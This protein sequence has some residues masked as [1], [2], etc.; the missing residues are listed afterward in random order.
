MSRVGA[1]GEAELVAM[2]QRRL[3]SEMRHVRLGMG[4]DGAI[5]QVDGDLVAT[6]DSVVAGVDWLPEATPRQAIGHRAAAVNLSDLAA[7]GARPAH[8]LVALELP[9]SLAV[10]DLNESLDGLRRLAERHDAAV[11]GG[12]VGIGVGPERW[13]VTA[14]G[15]LG[16]GQALLRS[17]ALPGYG[18][19]LVGTCG[20]AQ[21]GLTALR[22]GGSA[23]GLAACIEAHLRPQPQCAA[24]L[25]LAACGHS[26]AAIDVSDGLWLDGSRLA[27]ASGVDLRLDVPIPPW[28]S[29]TVAGFC[30]DVQLDWRRACASGGDDYALLVAAP[31]ALD[32]GAL[33]APLQGHGSA[34]GAVQRI[35]W[36]E[37]A[38]GRPTVHL[39]VGG[40]V[41]DGPPQG[42]LH[43]AG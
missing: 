18:V 41:F 2:I 20:A 31:A 16:E 30:A 21:V 40:L 29:A 36:A 11:V 27:E 37:A 28:L 35:G 39:A 17:A 43:G 32:L 3:R 5:V 12:D 25:M 23:G 8:L 7:M 19:W 13:T 34:V 33:L 22:H 14:L 15:H 1:L 4:D 26:I 6:V 42:Y 9:P 38:A 24:G 10:A